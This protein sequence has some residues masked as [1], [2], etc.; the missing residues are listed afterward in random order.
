M[1]R[2]RQFQSTTSDEKIASKYRKREESRGFLWTIDIPA[3]FVG[4]RD[5]SDVAWRA[6]ESETLFPPYSAFLVVS[7]SENGCHLL[8]VDKATEIGAN[9]SRHG[10]RGTRRHRVQRK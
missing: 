2:F 10:L 6:R 7:V 9:T 5:I 8:A 1:V 3:G 4:A